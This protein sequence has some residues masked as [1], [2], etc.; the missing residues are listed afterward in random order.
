MQAQCPAMPSLSLLVRSLIFD[1]PHLARSFL[2]SYRT[3]AKPTEVMRALR[4]VSRSLP[5][6]STRAP[7][8]R[9]LQQWLDCCFESDFYRRRLLNKLL[10]F[11]TAQLSEDD[12]NI[13]KLACLR[14]V[15]RA[16]PG[17]AP[18]VS[19]L[20]AQ[21]RSAQ[22]P[23]LPSTERTL[24]LKSQKTD[25]IARTLYAISSTLTVSVRVTELLNNNWQRPERTSLAPGLVALTN[26][27][28]RISFW[29]A[30]EILGSNP[31]AQP[32]KL[33][34]K[35]IKVLHACVEIGDMHSAAA[36]CAGLNL[37]CVQ[38]LRRAW[39]ALSADSRTHFEQADELLSPQKNWGRY[40]TH[41]R[42]ATA[43][44]A[45][46]VPY[47]AVLQRD[48]TFIHDGNADAARTAEERQGNWDKLQLFGTSLAAF[49]E[50]QARLV[51]SAPPATATSALVVNTDME[52]V[53]TAQVY[54]EDMLEML[55]E[56]FEPRKQAAA[57]ADARPTPSP[58]HLARLLTQPVN[59]WSA[60]DVA[61]WAKASFDALLADLLS[62]AAIDGPRLVFLDDVALAEIGVNKIGWRK[63]VIREAR[64]LALRDGGD[65]NSLCE[66]SSSERSASHPP[67]A[68]DAR[69]WS[70]ADV[71]Q[72]LMA[73]GEVPL[74]LA[75]PDLTGEDLAALDVSALPAEVVMQPRRLKKKL[76][77][78][79]GR[80]TRHVAG[81]RLSNRR[82]VR[83]PSQRP[84]QLS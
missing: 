84:L 81:S 40:R 80:P 62:E 42:D 82:R 14:G 52:A 7:V 11:A 26:Y 55:S 21:P 44:G 53:L 17:T 57:D 67:P 10:S 24:L 83:E 30:S 68:S 19:F 39:V 74:A 76:R 75:S 78:L 60:Q 61:V 48:F 70:A 77:K 34:K 18:R 20:L 3:C 49:V 69:R 63:R 6:P 65:S 13:L 28:N 64:H 45:A 35:A 16:S 27:F 1:E 54:G 2:L 29:I 36:V 5:S 4:A 9:F 31:D 8:A 79:F 72:W 59:T 41:M 71:K 73:L 37:S 46:V 66:S 15:A 12:R 51:R 56:R 38:R 25:A 32:V 22:L 58:T 23:L 33:L 43:N 47:M 50:A